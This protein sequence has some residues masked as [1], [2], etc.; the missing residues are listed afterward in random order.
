MTDPDLNNSLPMA[1]L[2]PPV[3][4]RWD[5]VVTVDALSPAARAARPTGSRRQKSPETQIKYP[6]C[7]E[8][9]GLDLRRPGLLVSLV[10]L[11]S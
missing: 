11:V 8:G 4:F 6:H 7:T 1:A 9:T 5:D 2:G 10:S 3:C